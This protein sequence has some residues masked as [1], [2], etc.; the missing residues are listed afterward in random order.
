M[1][2]HILDNMVFRLADARPLDAGSG[3]GMTERYGT[4]HSRLVILEPLV[5][6]SSGLSFV[7]LGP[8]PED[9]FRNFYPD[10]GCGRITVW[11]IGSVAR[12]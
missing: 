6:S 2:F 5:S 11:T 3:S 12:E 7:I 1:T 9:P 10:A 4:L 8:R